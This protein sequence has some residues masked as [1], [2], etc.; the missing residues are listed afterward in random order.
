[1]KFGIVVFPG[2]NCD[3]DTH[4][5]LRD[6]MG[7]ETVT[8]WHKERDLKGV[9]VV[10][11]PGGFSYGD[12]LRSGALARYSPVMESVKEFAEK[13]EGK[14]LGICNG[15][16]VLCEAGLLPGALRPNRQKR[17]VCKNIFLSPEVKNDLPTAELR[18]IKALRIPIAHGEGAY[19]ASREVLTRLRSRNQILFRYCDENGNVREAANPNGSVD[20]IAG[21]CSEN[22]CVIGMMPH[23]ERASDAAQ[24]N[25]D[26]LQILRSVISFWQHL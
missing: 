21:I 4:Y 17:F 2:S 24:A 25:T 6:I 23:P 3:C 19:Y 9:D 10:V 7:H 26:G 5:V 8:L 15:F 16:Q 20:N 22:R 12:Y 11:I 18:G 13:S 1:M 14:I